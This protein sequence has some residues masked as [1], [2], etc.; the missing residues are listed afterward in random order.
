MRF[1][2]IVVNV[3]YCFLGFHVFLLF[4][5]DI[6]YYFLFSFWFPRDSFYDDASMM[7]KSVVLLKRLKKGKKKVNRFFL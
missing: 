7:L 1:R 4:L 2:F 6:S 3:L 5:T